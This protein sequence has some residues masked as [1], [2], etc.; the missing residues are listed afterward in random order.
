MAAKKSL[1]DIAAKA[2]NRR[3]PKLA[4]EDRNDE[5]RLTFIVNGADHKAFKMEAMEA[6]LSM[7]DFFYRL[8][9]GDR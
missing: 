3:E 1:G 7:T 9:K 8:W 4:D 6:G 5:K 2:K